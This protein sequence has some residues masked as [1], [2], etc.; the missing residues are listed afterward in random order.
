LIRNI[1]LS[2]VKSLTS[3]SVVF[4]LGFFVWPCSSQVK[5]MFWKLRFTVCTW[6]ADW[7][8]IKRLYLNGIK[9]QNLK[10]NKTHLPTPLL[11]GIDIPPFVF[12]SGT[13]TLTFTNHYDASW[14]FW[15]SCWCWWW[16]WWWWWSINSW[17]IKLL[18][19][20]AFDLIT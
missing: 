3:I 2:R 7:E 4:H 14:L 6:C 20:L 12:L 17:M 19:L 5:Y 1:F 9:K 18:L 11:G 13:L 15:W 16:W 8:R 10:Y